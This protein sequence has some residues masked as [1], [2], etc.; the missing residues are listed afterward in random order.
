MRKFNGSWTDEIAELTTD[1]EYQDSEVVLIDSSVKPDYDLET[2]KYSYP[3]GFD[4]II[5]RGGAR[6]QPVRWGVFSGGE[7]QAN[8]KVATTI[9]IQIA[10]DG[11]GRIQRGTACVVISAPDNIAMANSLYNITSGSQGSAT[12][13]RTF[14]AAIDGDSKYD[15]EF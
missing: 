13:S 14:E 6:I 7:S 3:T 8:A 10:K 12:A 1:E 9:R 2:G 11:L 5:F 15:T 4:P